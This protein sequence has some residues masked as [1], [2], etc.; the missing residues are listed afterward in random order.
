MIESNKSNFEFLGVKYQKR[1]IRQILSDKNFAENI[2]DMI[3]VNYFTDQYLKIIVSEIK[4]A[5][6]KHEVIPDMESLEI[7]LNDRIEGELTRLSIKAQIKEIKDASDNDNLYIKDKAM[8]FCKQQELKKS[9][10]E[11]NEIIE[12]GTLDDYDRCEEILKQAL[13]L[14]MDKEQGVDVFHDLDSVLAEDFRK[15]IRTG[16]SGLDDKMDGGLSKNE[17][18]VILAPFGVG[19]TTMLTKVGNTAFNDGYRVLQIFFEDQTKVIQRKHISCWTGIELSHLGYPEHRAEI[20][21][22]VEQRNEQGG[23][24]TLVKYSSDGTTMTKI[25]QLV[26]KLTAQGKKPDVLILDYIDCISPTQA[27]N[28]EWNAEGAIMRQFETLLT[29]F[30][31]AGW[32][33][34]QG[35]R[36]SLMADRVD[37]NMI[38]GSIKKGQIGHFVVSIAKTMEQ[39]EQNTATMAIIKSRF[40]PDGI[41]FDDIVF[42]N[43]TLKIDINTGAGLTL[44]ER[45]KEKDDNRK[46]D[47]KKIML[48]IQ[49]QLKEEEEPKVDDDNNDDT[50]NSII[51]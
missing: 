22:V 2:I 32:T 40:G 37:A 38:G 49:S 35:N 23:S 20:N 18:A 3:D 19:K 31:L 15:P 4:N 5:Y 29:D 13:E 48:R 36:E 26:R 14:G 12:K 46:E 7:R 42:D 45:D 1:L 27:Y 51:V 43:K 33:A 11:I 10:K 21:R 24:L 17:L 50:T 8:K 41:V 16:I 39:K 28:S 47:M 34:I 25:R 44:T 6:D 30:D 9:V